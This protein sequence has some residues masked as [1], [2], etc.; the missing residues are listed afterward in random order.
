M[1]AFD[2]AEAL[3]ALGFKQEGFERGDFALHQNADDAEPVVVWLSDKLCPIPDEVRFPET[4]EARA[5]RLEDALVSKPYIHSVSV[6]APAPA[7]PGESFYQI[8]I[9][10][11]V[12][13]PDGTIQKL[14]SRAMTL[15]EVLALGFTEE[16]VNA[17]VPAASLQQV[18]EVMALQAATLEELNAANV[19]LQELRAKVAAQE[20]P[21]EEESKGFNL[22]KPSTWL[23]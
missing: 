11:H 8:I 18:D 13:G 7:L 19:E 3:K 22:F 20:A 15:P 14:L 6:S 4:P 12:K 1:S 10:D 21:A 16:Q 23:G 17:F 9:A 2:T 5:A